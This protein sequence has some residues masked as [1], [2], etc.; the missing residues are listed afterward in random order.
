MA[1]KQGIAKTISDQYQVKC[2][3][4]DKG[5]WSVNGIF[6]DGSSEAKKIAKKIRKDKN[7]SK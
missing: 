2:K 5:F 6:V 1:T 4:N 7:N 3:I